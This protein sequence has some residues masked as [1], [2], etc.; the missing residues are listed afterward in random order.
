MDYYQQKKVHNQST[1]RALKLGLGLGFGSISL[2]ILIGVKK[3]KNIVRNNCFHGYGVCVFF[4]KRPALF[5][6][7][8]FLEKD[9]G[10]STRWRPQS[11]LGVVITMT[12]KLPNRTRA[13]MGTFVGSNST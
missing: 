12:S 11:L 5:K 13:S 8:L 7:D 1:N 4:T 6:K 3:E 10:V 2:L 9:E